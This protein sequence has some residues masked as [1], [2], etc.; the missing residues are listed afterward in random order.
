MRILRFLEEETG[1]KWTGILFHYETRPNGNLAGRLMRLCEAISESF[2][3]PLILTP[4]QIECPGA[5]R[6]LGMA[7]VNSNLLAE[8][9][10][11]KIGMPPD[12]ALRVINDTP[13]LDAPI[14]ALT[15]GRIENPDVLVSYLRPYAAMNFIRRWQIVYGTNISIDISSLMAVCGCVAVRAYKF[16]EVCFSFGCPD[17]RKYGRIKD[18]KLIIGMPYQLAKELFEEDYRHAYV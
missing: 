11:E 17:S 10:S 4:E 18:D 6:C 14:T 9:I 12:S 16:R 8:K 13:C 3:H 7:G 15:I 1:A 2:A 5:C